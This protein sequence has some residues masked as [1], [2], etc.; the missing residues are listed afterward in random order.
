MITDPDEYLRECVR[1]DDFDIQAEYIRLPADLA[2]W[3][4]RYADA[5]RDWNSSKLELDMLCSTLSLAI[6]DELINQAKGGRVTLAEVEQV[7][8]TTPQ[9][10]D[11]KQKEILAEAD[12]ARLYGVVDAIRAKKEMLISLGAH[13]R[14]E[15][16]NDPLIR[17]ARAAASEVANHRR[18]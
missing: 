16:G 11:A 17:N 8:H 1:I 5:Y 2:Y 14:L 4:S 6:R 15:M 13:I 18:T 10:R 3:N 9:Y 7:L 12:K